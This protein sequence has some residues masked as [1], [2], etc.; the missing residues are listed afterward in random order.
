M[1]AYFTNFAS[2]FV[3]LLVYELVCWLFNK[4]T[5]KVDKIAEIKED[6]WPQRKCRECKLPVHRYRVNLDK[7]VTC[8]NCVSE[9]K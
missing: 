8:A 5:K 7:T 3:A 1:F 6:S 4:L 2:C 9:G